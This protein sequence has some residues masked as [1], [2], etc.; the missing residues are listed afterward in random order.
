MY[1]LWSGT[2]SS[3]PTIASNSST[4]DSKKKVVF[5]LARYLTQTGVGGVGGVCRVTHAFPHR[6]LLE[7]EHLFGQVGSLLSQ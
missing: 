5:L 1:W 2:L 6:K 4:C 7:S 3:L